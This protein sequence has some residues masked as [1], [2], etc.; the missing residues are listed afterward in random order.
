MCQNCC[1]SPNYRLL[2]LPAEAVAQLLKLPQ[3]SWSTATVSS[4]L[5][6]NDAAQ[7]QDFEIYGRKGS[8]IIGNT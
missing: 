8:I 4:T 1:L 5:G 2:W 3:A 7:A 6:E